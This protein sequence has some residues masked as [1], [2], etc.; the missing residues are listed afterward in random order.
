[1]SAAIAPGLI[2]AFIVALAAIVALRRSAIAARLVD[3]PNE[4]SLHRDPRPRI[5]GL[6][7]LVGALPVAVAFAP[8]EARLYAGIAAVVAVVSAF[9][10]AASLPVASR[11]GTHLV[12]A[13]LAVIVVGPPASGVAMAVIAILGIAWIANLYTFMDGADGLAGGMTVIGFATF[14]IAAAQAGDPGV[15][16][17][18][19]ALSAAALAFLAFNFPPASLFMGDAGSV[20]LG[21][22]AGAVGWHGVARG[23]WPAWFPVLVFSP[24][25]VDATVTLVRRLLAREP[26]WKAHRSHY[27][28]RLVLGGWSHRRLALVQWVVMAAAGTSALAALGE[29]AA[30]QSAIL[31]A[32]VLAYGAIGFAIDRRHPRSPAQQGAALR[33]MESHKNNRAPRTAAERPASRLEP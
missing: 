20:P 19:G 26:V 7:L 3:E 17:L 15:A 27:Y 1:L 4:R 2:L 21:F 11:L 8:G 23:L 16:L 13:A 6:G 24:F 33:D 12:A 30:R 22:L 10:D 28:Q 29:S 32:W 14:A 25:V 31:A 5:G 18:A 9:D